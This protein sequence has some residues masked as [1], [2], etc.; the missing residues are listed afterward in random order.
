MKG[1]GCAAAAVMVA[2]NTASA[3]AQDYAGATSAA[4]CA[5]AL[6]A[7]AQPSDPASYLERARSRH[8]NIAQGFFGS[9]GDNGATTLIF[10]N[11]GRAGA[12]S[13][14]RACAPQQGEAREACFNASPDCKR[15]I[16]C[17]KE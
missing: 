12:A 5:G 17:L 1:I 10:E 11:I 16:A 14:N 15:I 4:W 9:A 7:Y 13:C 3:L 8:L 2:L 6:G